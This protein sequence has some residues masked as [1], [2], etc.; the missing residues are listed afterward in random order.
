MDNNKQKAILKAAT[1]VFLEYGFSAATTDVIQRAANVSKKTMYSYFPSKESLFISVIENECAVMTKE[2]KSIQL[3]GNIE[4]TLTDLGKAYLELVLSSTAIALYRVV[5]A[6]APKFPE[7]GRQ[8]YLSG[9]TVI[10]EKLM[11]YLDKAANNGEINIQ[12]VG[13]A[14]ASALFMNMVRGE[15]QLE[16]LTHPHNAK[17]SLVQIDQWVKIA[18]KTFLSAFMQNLNK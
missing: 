16:Y 13:V 17:P 12:S 11:D 2:Y 9:P 6:E 7:I 4:K 15:A 8:F 5:I 1:S 18:V 10:Y 3:D 14:S